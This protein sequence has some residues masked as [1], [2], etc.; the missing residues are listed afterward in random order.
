[1]E[2]IKQEFNLNCCTNPIAMPLLGRGMLNTLD[3]DPG[4]I[5]SPQKE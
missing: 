5:S 1:M 3:R 2:M 4:L